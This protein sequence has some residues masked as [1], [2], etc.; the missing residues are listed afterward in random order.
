MINQTLANTGKLMSDTLI[1]RTHKPGMLQ[2]D[3]LCS[4]SHAAP[5]SVTENT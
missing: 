2:L 3:D 4:I 1:Q 5:M